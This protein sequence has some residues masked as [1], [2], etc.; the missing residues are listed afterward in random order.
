[1]LALRLF[2]ISH[3]HFEGTWPGQGLYGG[4]DLIQFFIMFNRFAGTWQP[5]SLYSARGLQ[6]WLITNNRSGQRQPPLH[7]T[8]SKCGKSTKYLLHSGK[9]GL[10]LFK[11]Y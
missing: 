6:M 10:E 11:P 4:T 8:K 3:N 9:K 7:M 5:H 2:S 1:M